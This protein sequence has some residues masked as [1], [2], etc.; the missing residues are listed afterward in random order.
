MEKNSYVL[1]WLATMPIIG[2]LNKPMNYSENFVLFYAP[3]NQ[4]HACFICVNMITIK[5][6]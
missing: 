5:Y 3:P 1:I 6:T 4:K 2:L